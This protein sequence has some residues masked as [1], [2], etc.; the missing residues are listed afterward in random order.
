MIYGKHTAT[1][2][3]S[4]AEARTAA[5]RPTE[6][7][8]PGAGMTAAQ[9]IIAGIVFAVFLGWLGDKIDSKR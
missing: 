6:A 2:A 3:R 4:A 7:M 9:M 1:A 5:Y 8:R